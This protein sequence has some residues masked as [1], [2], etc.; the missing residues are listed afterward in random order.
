MRVGSAK[1]VALGG[2]L[3][4]LA[5]VIM[6]LGGLI[7]VATFVCPVLCLVILYLVCHLCGK[8]I[9][10]A[11]YGAVSIL[12]VLLG[13][14]KEAAAV[15]AFLG[16]YPIVKHYLEKWPLSLMWKLLFFN[17]ALAVMYWLLL[18]VFGLAEIAQEYAEFGLI[19][20]AIMVLLGNATFVLL[21]LLLN[22][23]KN[24]L[25]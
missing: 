7:P 21:D 25:R 18:S 3:A 4:A 8:R 15:F 6:C 2:I 13:P 14:D 24:R 22:K 5:T 17:I 12:A 19:S 23:I 11:W 16:W 20:G 1:A 9:G 10:W